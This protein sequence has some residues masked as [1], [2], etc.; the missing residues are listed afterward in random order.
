MNR[1]NFAEMSERELENRQ[2]IM[3]N[4]FYLVAV[5]G[6][7]S[8]L[9]VMLSSYIFEQPLS[10]W[11]LLF[12]TGLPLYSAYNAKKELNEIKAEFDRR[13]YR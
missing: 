4:S 11:T 2:K 8:T 1:K 12:T 9:G 5:V 7:I 3:K 6:V 13:R 10:W